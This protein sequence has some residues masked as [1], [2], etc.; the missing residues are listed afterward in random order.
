MT[1]E[2]SEPQ[3]PPA[4][5]APPKKKNVF[6]RIAGV[7]FAPGETFEEIARKPDIVAPILLIVLLGFVST[8][9]IVPRF[10][11]DSFVAEQSAQMREKNPNITAADS[12]RFARIGAA[13]TKVLLWVSPLL[14]IVAYVVIAGVF[15]LAFRLMGGEGNFTQAFSVT[16]YAW[17][18]FVISGIITGIVVV[19]RGSFDPATAATLVKSNPAFLV[20]VK[21]QPVLFSLLAS[22]DVF[23]IWTLLLYVFG[24]SAM[25]RLSWAKSAAIVFTVWIAFVLVKVGFAAIG[26]AGAAA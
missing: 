17:I 20:D 9:L 25:S 7:L 6:E 4:A 15:L 21:E 19:S 22:L 10:D 14:G 13:S 18:P 8:F 1:T 11:F 23:T 12:E 3:A 16:L 5:A 2:I 24:F 26:A